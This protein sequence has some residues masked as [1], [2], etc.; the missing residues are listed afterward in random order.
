MSV[1]KS[2]YKNNH[3]K[4]RKLQLS[5]IFVIGEIKMNSKHQKK[6]NIEDCGKL[7]G[8]RIAQLRKEKGWTQADFA[9]K[10]STSHDQVKRYETARCMIPLEYVL[11]YAQALGVSYKVLLQDFDDEPSEQECFLAKA[12]CSRIREITL[13]KNEKLFIRS[14]ED[15]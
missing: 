11:R 7:V 13:G 15:T 1:N 14:S 12:N 9:E 5:S 6:P 8:K 10:S 4:Y 2:F 3:T